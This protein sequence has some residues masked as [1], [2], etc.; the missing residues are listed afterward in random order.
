MMISTLPIPRADHQ[1]G[2]DPVWFGILMVLLS[3][4]LYRRLSAFNPRLKYPR[5]RPAS[6]RRNRFGGLR[7]SPCS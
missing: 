7:T 3:S 2:Y 6:R 4:A 1:A 5:P